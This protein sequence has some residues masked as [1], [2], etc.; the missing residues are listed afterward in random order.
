VF[1]RIFFRTE[2]LEAARQMAS[3]L[4]DSGNFEVRTGL[5]RVEPLAALANTNPALGW[6]APLAE[7]GVLI[8]LIGGFLLHYLPAR[9]VELGAMR[10]IPRVP[11]VAVGMGVA[12]V[13]GVLS[14][15][16]AGPRANIYFA[17]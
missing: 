17:F 7:W 10:L 1:G 12:V 4:L 2:N 6:L 8:L 14:L 11:A 16:Q 3:S 13:L 15:L 9:R 5:F